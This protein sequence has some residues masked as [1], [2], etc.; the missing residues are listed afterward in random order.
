MNEPRLMFA[1][2]DE[3][4]EYKICEILRSYLI[5]K[6]GL[7]QMREEYERDEEAE[8]EQRL[9]RKIHRRNRL[10]WQEEEAD[11]D[12]AER[13]YENDRSER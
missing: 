1:E 7:K 3:V 9:A 13:S 4:Q 5:K 6:K 2:S 10:A 8:Y 12:Y 11:R